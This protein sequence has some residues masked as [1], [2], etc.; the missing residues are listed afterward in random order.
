[1]KQTLKY[2][3]ERLLDLL[4]I[5]EGKYSIAI[6]LASGV[7][8]FG[9]TFIANQHLAIRVLSGGSIVFALVSVIYG[10]VAL[11]A[12]TVKIKN[13]S[14]ARHLDNLLFYKN[15]MKFD[16]ESYV[17]ALKKNYN[18]PSSYKPDGFDLDLAKNVIAQARVVFLKFWYL[19][20]S[21]FFLILSILLAVI[22]VLVL[23]SV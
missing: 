5:A 3:L 19:N 10:F 14:K 22:M 21:L 23:G 6:A 7:I 13:K 1:M 2:I 12:R 8:V 11:F 18:F 16:A 15:I 20:I 9:A 17:D 4:K